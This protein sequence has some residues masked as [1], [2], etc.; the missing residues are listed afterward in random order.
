MST[1]QYTNVYD[2]NVEG[3]VLDFRIIHIYLLQI[4]SSVSEF[5]QK[6]VLLF[7]LEIPVLK[8][9]FHFYMLQRHRAT[10]LPTP[11][12]TCKDICEIYRIVY[13]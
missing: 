13:P 4:S 12:S 3:F 11:T 9:R 7:C 1:Q 10:F 5:Q 6:T 8:R 2:N